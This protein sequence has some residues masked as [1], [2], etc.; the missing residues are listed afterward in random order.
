[1][2]R[3]GRDAPGAGV[4]SRRS[5]GNHPR[6]LS[7]PG[8]LACRTLGSR[9][10]RRLDA[11]VRR[12]RRGHQ[13]GRAIGQ[14]PLQREESPGDHAFTGRLHAR[15]RPGDR[16]GEAAAI[17]VAADAHRYDAPNDDESGI[18]GGAE[19]EAPDTWR[20]SIDVATAWERALDEADV[21][22]TRKIKLRSAVILSPDRGGIFDTIL[23]LVRK[24]LGG[25]A[26]DGKQYVSWIH[27]A[28][29]V[30]AVYWLLD[31][32]EM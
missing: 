12:R 6:A 11:L 14:L 32:R 8:A 23:G 24:G 20:F 28:D 19:A 30:R 29:F 15:R 9:W 22:G 18:L 3:A 7:G 26:C 4:S 31:R 16:P 2:H 17:G 5:R 10:A 21:P 27:D 25:T 13:H 1:R